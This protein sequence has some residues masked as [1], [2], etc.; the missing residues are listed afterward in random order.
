MALD[1]NFETVVDSLE[2]IRWEREW[3]GRLYTRQPGPVIVI[4]KQRAWATVLI[5]QQDWRSMKKGWEKPRF[6]LSRW[7]KERGAW[8]IRGY[9]RLSF[10][11][12]Q[13]FGKVV[14]DT[15]LEDIADA[16]SQK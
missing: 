7:C 10:R 4:D 11:D 2:D 6:V 12:A 1:S 14:T 15:Y 3:N 13:A 9:L 8:R 5:P 16:A